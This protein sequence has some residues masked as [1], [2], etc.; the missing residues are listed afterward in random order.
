M[1]LKA[2]ATKLNTLFLLK[3]H[4]PNFH[5]SGIEQHDP[6]VEKMLHYM[7]KLEARA[8]YACLSHGGQS[9]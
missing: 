3:F 4:W 6:P 7:F 2:S 9:R 8:G 1:A 5:D